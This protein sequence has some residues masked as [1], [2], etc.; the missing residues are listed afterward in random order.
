MFRRISKRPLTIT[1]K[2]LEI[3]RAI[4]DW[5]AKVVFHYKRI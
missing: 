5:V 1:K 3:S 2:G 4:G